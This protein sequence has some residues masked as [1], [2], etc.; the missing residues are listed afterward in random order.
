MASP[1]LTNT[2]LLA[3]LFLQ[4]VIVILLT[5]DFRQQPEEGKQSRQL[6]RLLPFTSKIVLDESSGPPYV[7]YANQVSS[8]D[9]KPSHIVIDTYPDFILFSKETGAWDEQLMF[10]PWSSVAYIEGEFPDMMRGTSK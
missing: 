2:L 3:M 4:S 5:L 7:I 6:K 8:K 10:I 9:G 1:K